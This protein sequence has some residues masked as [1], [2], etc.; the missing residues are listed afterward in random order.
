MRWP[1]ASTRSATEARRDDRSKPTSR[2][3]ECLRRLRRAGKSLLA[4]IRTSFAYM[5][6]V[7]DPPSS[8]HRLT[9]ETLARQGTVGDRLPGASRRRHRRLRLHCR[10]RPTISTS[11]SWLS[12]SACRAMASAARLLSAAEQHAVARGQAAARTADAGRTDRQ[13]SRLSRTWLS[14]RRGGRRIPAMIRPTSVTM[15]K[16]LA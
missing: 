3:S 1:R 15:R 13:P 8:V 14:S 6:G 10:A 2:S 9:S 4:I 12:A 11:A 16:R 7:I 5:D